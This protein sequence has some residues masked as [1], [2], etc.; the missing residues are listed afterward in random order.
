MVEVNKTHTVQRGECAWNVAKKNLQSKGTKSTNADIAK[1]MQRLANLNGCESVEDFNAKYF[2]SVGSE[3]VCEENKQEKKGADVPANQHQPTK[4]K[5]PVK[6]PQ[7]DLSDSTNIAKRDNTNVEIKVPVDSLRVDKVKQPTDSVSVKKPAPTPQ[8][9]PEEQEVQ[10]IN[11]LNTDTD[12]I[13]EYNKKNYDGNH[14]AIVDKKTCQLKIYDRE[15]NVLKTL[16]VGVGKKVGDNLGTYY[17]DR[18]EKTKDAYKAEQGRYTTPGE[19]TLDEYKKGTPDYISKKDGKVKMMGL[20]GDNKGE[21]AGQQA[22]H[23]IPNSHQDRNARIDSVTTDDNRMSYGCVNLKESDFD[24]LAQYVGE[25]DK[26]YILPEENGNKLQLEKQQDGSYRF[27]QQHHKDQKRGVP[28]EL[29][30]RVNYDVRPE[31]NPV[32]I[33]QQKQKKAEQERLL[34]Q[35][36]AEQKTNEFCWYKPTTWFS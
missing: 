14:Y 7:V 5:E 2:S 9:S 27:E 34:A 32:Y 3:F 25:G 20:K 19:F 8:L 36:Q 13:V 23:M 11:S 10:R 15:G 28:K 16:T 21:R 17:L 4:S 26:I 30:S 24:V 29:A 35:Q 33:A 1:E 18:A 6:L 12:R 22:I 31:K